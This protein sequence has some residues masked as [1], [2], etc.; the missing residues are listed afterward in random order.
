[1]QV[2]VSWR[3]L[4]EEVFDNPTG[5]VRDHICRYVESGGRRGHRFNGR[6]S[7]LITTR[8]RRSGR[9]RRTA[10]YYG[11]DGARY[12]LVATAVRGGG[13]PSWY[14]NVLESPAVVLQVG[15]HSFAALA[16]PAASAER[17][18]LWELML[19]VFPKYAAYEREAGRP[20]PVVVVDAPTG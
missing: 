9:L 20:L 19:G 2:S 5:W 10:L 11:R 16:R 17:A 1:M 4:P 6:D 8:G 15:T 7:L 13:D 18:R 3:S 14:L 12:V